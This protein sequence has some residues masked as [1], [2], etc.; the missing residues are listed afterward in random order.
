METELKF[1][2]ILVVFTHNTNN[3]LRVLFKKHFKSFSLAQPLSLS[4]SLSRAS[5]MRQPT[6][7]LIYEERTQT[8]QYRKGRGPIRMTV[9]FNFQSFPI[10]CC[11]FERAEAG[12]SE[13]MP[14]TWPIKQNTSTTVRSI[15][16][17][18]TLL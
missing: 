8:A 14:L 6:S 16:H 3:R 7:T 17:Q 5:A 10:S 11:L 15:G 12:V 18:N 2:G 9:E 1:G 13:W 4:L